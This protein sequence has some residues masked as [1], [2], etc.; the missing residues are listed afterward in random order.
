M[1]KFTSVQDTEV[2]RINVETKDSQLSKEICDAYMHTAQEALDS[3]VGAGSVKVISKP[4]LSQKPS[5]PNI[6]LFT[7]VGAIIGLL[8]MIGSSFVSMKKSR[9]ISDEKML[10][11]QYSIPLLGS[12]PDFFQFS[13]ALGISKGDVKKSQKLKEKNPDNEKIKTTI[14]SRTISTAIAITFFTI[15]FQIPIF[16]YHA[17]F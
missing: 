12:V 17:R 6:P 2:L 10:T 15:T 4:Q 3:I 8:L 14:T 9:P 5:Y 16:T 11:E 13:K 7:S 1:T